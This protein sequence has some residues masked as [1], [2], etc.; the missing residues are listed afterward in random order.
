MITIADLIAK[1]SELELVHPVSGDKLG[2]KL[3]VVGKDSKEFLKAAEALA[4]QKAKDDVSFED[5]LKTSADFV[6][7]LVTGWSS[8]EFFGGP[9]S[10]EALIALLSN[11]A[12]AWLKE[13]LEAF[14]ADRKNFFRGTH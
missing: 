4:K 5:M 12:Y 13:Q 6:A 14:V 7:A 2:V 10:R 8:D 3:T 1:E 9:F 11:P